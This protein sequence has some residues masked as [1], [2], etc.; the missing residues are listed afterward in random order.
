[1]RNGPAEVVARYWELMRQNQFAKISELLHDDFTCVWP[2]SHE[3]IRGPEAFR[4][5]NADYPAGARWTFEVERAAVDGGAVVT[6]TRVSDGR[7]NARV[8][9]FFTVDAGRIVRMHEYWPD[10]YPAPTHRRH[11]VERWPAA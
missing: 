9:T 8:I 10:D 6:D 7:T 3:L 11:L 2:Q 5:I 4:L 1:M